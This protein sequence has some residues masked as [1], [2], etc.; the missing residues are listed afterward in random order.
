M[1]ALGAA[2]ARA[3]RW[4]NIGRPVDFAADGSAS[5][6]KIPFVRFPWAMGYEVVDEVLIVLA[7]FHQHRQPD[8]WADR[9]NR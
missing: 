8:Y 4:P 3:R 6:R 5:Y 1:A 7:V 2:V 9:S